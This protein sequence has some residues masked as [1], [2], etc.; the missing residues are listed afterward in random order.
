MQACIPTT[1]RAVVL[2][3]HGGIDKLVYREDVPTPAPGPG[4][5][6]IQ[7]A[8]CGINNTDINTRTAWYSADVQTGITETGGKQGFDNYQDRDATW[9]GKPLSFPRI[10]GADIAGHI[11]AVGVGLDAARI[12]ERVITDG[13]LRDPGDP[14][15][16]SKA[17]Y[18]GSE[19]DGGYAQYATIPATNAHPVNCDLSDIELAAINV[20]YTTAENLLTKVRL[21]KGESILI[22]GASGGV[23]TAMIQLAK[24]RGARVIAMAS[25]A[26]FDVLRALGADACLARDNHDV[27]AA[28]RVAGELDTVDVVGDVVGGPAFAGIIDALRPGGR[29]GISGAI[30]GPEVGL[31]LRHLIYRDLEFYGAT[32]LPP[33]VFANLVSYVEQGEIRPLIAKTFPLQDLGAAQAEFI[34]KRHVGNFVI[35]IDAA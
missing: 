11:V 6:L 20:A 3:G 26:K 2:T 4:E 31:N 28:L 13:W 18:F 8:A 19:R 16:P 14:L 35:V 1:M 29:Y 33:V 10:Q 27:R 25:P 15:N 24:R 21:D 5:V 22:T 17:G 32:F 23:G 9:G 34:E 7:V 30:A 12:G